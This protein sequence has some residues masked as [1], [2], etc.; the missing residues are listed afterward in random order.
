MSWARGAMKYRNQ[1]LDWLLIVAVFMTFVLAAAIFFADMAEG[2]GRSGVCADRGN[3][4]AVCSWSVDA[5]ESN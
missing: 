3:R 2:Q 1:A 5:A 4:A